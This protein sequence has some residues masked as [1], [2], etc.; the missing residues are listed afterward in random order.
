M[1]SANSEIYALNEGITFIFCVIKRITSDTF[2]IRYIFTNTCVVNSQRLNY[3]V[4]FGG[5]L[6]SSYAFLFTKII[7]ST[8]SGLNLV[9]IVANVCPA[10]DSKD[11]SDTPGTHK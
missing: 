3:R 11:G 2:T 7:M 6:V 1:L 9:R 4:A 5:A 8:C 10:S